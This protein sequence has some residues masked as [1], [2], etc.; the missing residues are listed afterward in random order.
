MLS[1]YTANR[2]RFMHGPH[3]SNEKRNVYGSQNHSFC[4][5][6]A[7]LKNPKHVPVQVKPMMATFGFMVRV[8]NSP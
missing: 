6:T 8:L 3:D 1:S 7:T 4:F 5:I 2:C